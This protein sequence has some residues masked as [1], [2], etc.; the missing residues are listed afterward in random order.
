LAVAGTVRPL[1]F[2]DLRAT[3]EH[4]E[5]LA[6]ATGGGIAWLAEGV[7]EFRRTGVGRD[8]A[9]RGWIGLRRNR[10]YV[11]T[12]LEEIS[13]LPGL[14]VLTLVLGGLAG[15]WWRESR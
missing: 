13:L 15:A 11:V 4:L 12:G 5:P 8:T 10:S 1:E 6:K 14:I 3:A 7:P 9:G 2:D